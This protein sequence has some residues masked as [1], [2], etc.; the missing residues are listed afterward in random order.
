[1]SS[2]YASRLAEFLPTQEELEFFVGQSGANRLLNAFAR[3]T[4]W[5]RALNDVLDEHQTSV[6]LSAAHSKVIETW[7]LVPL[8]LLHTSYTALRTVVDISTSYTFYCS[9]PAEWLAVCEGR[10]GWEARANI[11]DWHVHYTPYFRE[12]NRVFGLGQGLNDDYQKLSSYVHGIPV[13]GLPTLKGI[14]RTR[15]S[16]ED[17][18]EFITLAEVV[19]KNLSL[20]FLGVFHPHL[21]A[22]STRDFRVITDGIDRRKLAETGIILPRV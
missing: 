18:G 21:V 5:F 10:S 3:I 8:G 6:L 13:A 15:V 12:V 11:V 4:T 19:D 20:L 17:L 16:D 9:H 1:M 14:Q 2:D 7:I 22:V